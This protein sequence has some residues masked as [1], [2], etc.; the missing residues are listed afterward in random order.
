MDA[1]TTGALGWPTLRTWG[2]RT[3]NIEGWVL[4]MADTEDQDPWIANV[5]D[6]G[7]MADVE[8]QDP[9]MA[10]VE[11]YDPWFQND[12]HQAARN[13]GALGSPMTKMAKDV[14]GQQYGWWTT[15]MVDDADG[16]P[17]GPQDRSMMRI[18]YN[19]DNNHGTGWANDSEG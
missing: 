19:K 15:W 4:L 7:P 17:G 13:Q 2:L 9:Q 1:L 18:A 5:E 16:P 12:G 11:E 6:P 3:A 14:N 8:D 10:N